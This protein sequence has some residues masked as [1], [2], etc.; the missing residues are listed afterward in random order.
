[1]SAILYSIR[2]SD[3]IGV[4]ATATDQYIFLG[5]G[6]GNRDRKVLSESLSVDCVS[7]TV[8]YSDLVGIFVRANSNGIAISNLMEKSEEEALRKQGLDINIGIVDSELN[9]IGNNVLANDKIAIVHPEY[10]AKAIRQ[11]EDIL[12][13]EVIKAPDKKFKTV[14]ASNILTNKGLVLNNRSTESGEETM[15]RATHFKPVRSTANTGSI[16]T[17]I[18][19]IANSKGIVAGRG[20]TAFELERIIE[21]LDL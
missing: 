1:M 20:T 7:I 21:G 2:N 15:A 4:F 18:G 16:Y 5:A 6:L 13:V 12:G 10:D 9:A 11:I 3:H 19:V 17:G 14:G 8:S